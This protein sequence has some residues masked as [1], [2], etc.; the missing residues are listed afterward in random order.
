V[1]TAVNRRT[2]RFAGGVLTSISCDSARS[3]IAV[4]YSM[5]STGSQQS[6][7]EQWDGTS[8]AILST[9]DGP[10]P[11]NTYLNAIDCASSVSCVAVGYTYEPQP[12]TPVVELWNGTS[13]SMESTAIP[14]G[15]A[16]ESVTCPTVSECMAAG[17]GSNDTWLWNGASW[18]G[19]ALAADPSGPTSFY[20][21]A[22]AGPESC[23]AVGEYTTPTGHAIAAAQSWNGADWSQQQVS[24]PS[25]TGA[26]L[27]D[28][29]CESATTCDA[30][31]ISGDDPLAEH[32]SAS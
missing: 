8:W 12:L 16:L 30:V 25:G 21:V 26:V 23:E 18:S 1:E 28:V 15:E 7:A 6:L 14:A 9:P 29:M 24:S 22:C 3:C 5:A 31:G 4:G 11:G 27:D 2:H 17:T 20:S 32:Y 19:K 13:W 10:A